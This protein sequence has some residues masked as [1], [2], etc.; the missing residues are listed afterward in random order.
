MSARAG[1][2]CQCFRA[3]LLQSTKCQAFLKLQVYK[4]TQEFSELSTEY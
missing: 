4:M 1:M 2:K 3:V